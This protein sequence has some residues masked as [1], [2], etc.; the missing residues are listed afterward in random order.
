[1]LL[2]LYFGEIPSPVHDGETWSLKDLANVRGLIEGK[3]T[4]SGPAHSFSWLVCALLLF[5]TAALVGGLGRLLV[6]TRGRV[7]QP[8]R[9]MAALGLLQLGI[10]NGLWLYYD[11]YYLVLLPP[12]IYLA[13]KLTLETGFSRLLAWS[14]V[15]VLSF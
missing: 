3:L 7:S 8:S 2:Y 1:L 10:I 6:K 4:A 5:S 13:L 14:G 12:L 9:L 11:R 15:A